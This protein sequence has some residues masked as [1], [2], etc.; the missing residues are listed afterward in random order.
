M[1]NG[2]HETVVKACDAFRVRIL[3][4]PD[5]ASP[6]W[7]TVLWGTQ[8]DIGLSFPDW[9]VYAPE[10]FAAGRTSA[11]EDL[12]VLHELAHLVHW[13]PERGL[14]MEEGWWMPW[15][16][17]VVKAGVG[18]AQP[19]WDSPFTDLTTI[20][21]PRRRQHLEVQTW[22]RPSRAW[23]Y[24]QGLSMGQRLGTLDREGQVT[25]RRPEWGALP[26][27]FG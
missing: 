23:W 8:T 18:T 12:G 7:G 19:Y 2:L 11:V 24:R 10:K 21:D 22:R 5:D 1:T 14:D 6:V 13:H 9:A 25:W 17:A 4:A 27:Y 3:Q 20:W 15:E 16:A 26:K